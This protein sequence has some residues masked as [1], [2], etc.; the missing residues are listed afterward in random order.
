MARFAK[1]ISLGFCFFSL[2]TAVFTANAT[3]KKHETPTRASEADHHKKSLSSSQMH[4]ESNTSPEADG[5]KQN[6]VPTTKFDNTPYRFNM[7]Q[8]GKKMTA[9][10]FDAWM[11]KNNFH[12]VKSHPAA[13]SL[14]TANTTATTSRS[15]AAHNK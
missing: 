13:V 1:C 9:N 8:N 11:K 2:T 6:Y 3:V 4:E 7:N 14:P 12:V 5:H 10:E 15:E